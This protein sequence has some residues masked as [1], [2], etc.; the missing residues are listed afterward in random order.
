[1]PIDRMK[2]SDELLA[3]N[4]LHLTNDEELLVKAA[5]IIR[6]GFD[7][8]CLKCGNPDLIEGGDKD[9]NS[10]EWHCKCGFSILRQGN[11]WS[12]MYFGKKLLVNDIEKFERVQEVEGLS[13]ADQLLKMIRDAWEGPE[14]ISETNA[15]LMIS[16]ILAGLDACAANAF[17]PVDMFDERVDAIIYKNIPK[18]KWPK[19]NVF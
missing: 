8:N 2:I 15:R 12:Q 18:E 14:P 4:A 11:T 19:R 7:L 10:H 6:N 5:S 17:I 9:D 16:Y 1:M 13:L 3:L